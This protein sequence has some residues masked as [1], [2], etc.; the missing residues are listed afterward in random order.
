MTGEEYN[1]QKCPYC[2]KTTNLSMSYMAEKIM[3]AIGSERLTD[4]NVMNVAEVRAIYAF[5]V[6]KKLIKEKD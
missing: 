3:T 5:F 1:N 6:S 2:K 4:S